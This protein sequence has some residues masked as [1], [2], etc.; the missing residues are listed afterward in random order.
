M[1]SEEFIVYSLYVNT[2]NK[3]QKKKLA[4]FYDIEDALIFVR[5]YF[6]YY[7][8]EKDLQLSIERFSRGVEDNESKN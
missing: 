2:D 3:I 8:N 7:Y 6:D 5:A 4:F 1:P